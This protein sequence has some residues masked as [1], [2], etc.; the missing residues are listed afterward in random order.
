MTIRRTVGLAAIGLVATTLG[1][2]AQET[3]SAAPDRPADATAVIRALLA[4]R[5]FAAVSPLAENAYDFATAD[6]IPGFGPIDGADS[7][8]RLAIWSRNGG[9]VSRAP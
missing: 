5:D 4:D 3:T 8:R 7:E 2:S 1:A 6:A 9:A